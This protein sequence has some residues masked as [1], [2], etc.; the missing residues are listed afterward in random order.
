MNKYFYLIFCL[1]LFSCGKNNDPSNEE[2]LVE[3]VKTAPWNEEEIIAISSDEDRKSAVIFIDTLLSDLEK[4]HKFFKSHLE[5]TES[6]DF[7][8]TYTPTIGGFVNWYGHTSTTKF[9]VDD[10][11]D[12]IRI[13]NGGESTYTNSTYEFKGFQDINYS[14][15]G[16]LIVKMNL[17]IDEQNSTEKII[18]VDGGVSYK[19]TEGVRNMYFHIKFTYESGIIN[20][21]TFS[22]SVNGVE[23]EGDLDVE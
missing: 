5:E 1:I 19:D 17:N 11:T 13:G 4:P 10:G 8:L 2:L 22:A 18:V 9:T 6:N 15:H 12:D 7:S 3:A 20:K 21:S 23:I 16:T 14:V